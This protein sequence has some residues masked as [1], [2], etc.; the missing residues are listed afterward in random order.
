MGKSAWPCLSPSETGSPKPGAKTNHLTRK[1]VTL[2]KL[3]GM[4]LPVNHPKVK[5]I[6]PRNLN[7][8]LG[9]FT[10]GRLVINQVNTNELG[11]LRSHNKSQSTS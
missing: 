1:L 10:V 6:G 9:L 2:T 4:L 3:A 5:Q 7:V 8:Y 11:C